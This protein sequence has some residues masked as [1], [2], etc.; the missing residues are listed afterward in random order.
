[1]VAVTSSGSVSWWLVVLPAFTGLLGAAIV[2]LYQ[3]RRQHQQWKN[4]ERL[5]IY[6]DALD[7]LFEFDTACLTA[8]RADEGDWHA[9]VVGLF[10]SWER[11]RTKS[12]RVVMI[13]PSAVANMFLDAGTSAR[14]ITEHVEE[15]KTKTQVV[16]GAWKPLLTEFQGGITNFILSA[17][18]HLKTE[19]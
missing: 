16:D 6:S 4:D 19:N 14:K 15:F 18:K 10:E 2:A 3:G 9:A 17:T 11:L 8:E 7:L 13:G 1:V 5:S 12:A